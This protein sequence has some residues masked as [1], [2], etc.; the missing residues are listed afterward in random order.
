MCWH[1][2]GIPASCGHDVFVRR[3]GSWMFAN[4]A[5]VYSRH[6]KNRLNGEH[7]VVIRFKAKVILRVNMEYQFASI[8][9]RVCNFVKSGMHL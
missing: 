5:I 8:Q 1:S 7:C 9:N 3:L 4:I 6:N 2:I